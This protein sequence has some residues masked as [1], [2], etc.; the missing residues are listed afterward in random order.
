MTG[1]ITGPLATIAGIALAVVMTRAQMR[2]ERRRAGRLALE[3]LAAE[4]R[5]PVQHGEGCYICRPDD[6]DAADEA[7]ARCDREF[8]ANPVPTP[9]DPDDGLMALAD[10]VQLPKRVPG[11][12]ALP[13][14][15]APAWLLH[16]LYEDLRRIEGERL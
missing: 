12:T 4:C 15:E 9:V 5:C 11:A 10:A 14:P 7:C 13:L 2:W 6:P 16:D 8:W 3:R 1:A